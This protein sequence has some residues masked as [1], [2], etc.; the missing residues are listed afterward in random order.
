[1]SNKSVTCLA[2]PNNPSTDLL[3]ARL[4]NGDPE[5]VAGGAAD[6]RMSEAFVF[7]ENNLRAENLALEHR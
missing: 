1:M 3:S 6:S 5:S 7:L 4:L 2:K